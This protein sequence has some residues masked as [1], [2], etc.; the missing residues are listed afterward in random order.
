M[1]S[2]IGRVG[3]QPLGTVHRTIRGVKVVD[4][5]LR[6][7][8]ERGRDLLMGKRYAFVPGSERSHL[9]SLSLPLD[10]GLRCR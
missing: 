6:R 9:M 1:Y 8:I 5:F 10:F 3:I 7:C 2:E 4:Q